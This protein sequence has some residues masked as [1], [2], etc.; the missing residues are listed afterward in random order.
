MTTN[1]RVAIYTSLLYLHISVAVMVQHMDILEVA[2]VASVV[3]TSILSDIGRLDQGLVSLVDLYRIGHT[4]PVFVSCDDGG[5]YL[6]VPCDQSVSNTVVGIVVMVAE[7]PSVAL[8]AAVACART[9][10]VVDR[11][12]GHC[13]SYACTEPAVV[14]GAAAAGDVLDVG[15]QVKRVAWGAVGTWEIGG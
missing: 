11:P 6:A 8:G 15:S 5:A 7:S 12:V 1:H 14:D 13:H 4:Q 10:D 3:N 2:A 9:A